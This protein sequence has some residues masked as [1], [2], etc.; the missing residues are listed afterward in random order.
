MKILVTGKGGKS[1][2]WQIRAEQLGSAIG[3]TVQPMAT[4]FHGVDV[5]V[6]VK[7][8]PPALVDAI[9]RSGKPW[10]YD[11]VDGWPQDKCGG[12][13]EARSRQWLRSTLRS[14]R[15]HAVVFGTE[16]MQ[17]DSGFSGPSLVLPHHSWPKYL[18]RE[19]EIRETVRT[20][21][22]EGAQHYLGRW[23]CLL[24]AECNRRG[25]RLQINGDMTQ[26]DIGIALRDCGGYPARYWKP[27]TKLSNLHA[28]GIA[29]LC[30]LEDG[31]LSVASGREHWIDSPQDIAAA[32]DALE[33]VSTRR[34]I[35]ADHRKAAVPLSQ[36]A[37]TYRDWLCT[38]MR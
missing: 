24:M 8:T 22:Y 30:S 34:S 29:A 32:F 14:L 23:Q 10:V 7:R 36:V 35:S 19:P 3:A 18:D 25:W 38:L 13:D 4:D 1:G 27:G 33:D 5:V 15:P 31:Y 26:A 21:G 16:R 2:S 6:V 20:I 9:R 12:W 28:L 17:A 37:T 11:V